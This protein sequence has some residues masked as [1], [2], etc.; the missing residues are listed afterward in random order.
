MAAAEKRVN[1]SWC[2]ITNFGICRLMLRNREIY[3]KKGKGLV[4]LS[5]LLPVLHGLLYMMA[6][7]LIF[8]AVQPKFMFEQNRRRLL[9]IVILS[10]FSVIYLTVEPIDPLVYVLHLT[11]LSI[12]LAALYE[13]TLPGVFTWTAFVVCGIVIVGNDWIST[14]IACTICLIAGLVLHNR[15]SDVSFRQMSIFSLLLSLLYIFS[16]LIIVYIQGNMPSLDQLMLIVAA[17]IL[18]SPLVSFIYLYVKY[19][20]RFQR[21]LL[22]SEKNQI[23]GQLAAALSHEV[24]NPLTSARGF[25]QLLGKEQLSREAL[26]RY[27][28]YAMEGIDQANAIITDYLNFSK[29]HTEEPQ[30]LNVRDEVDGIIPWLQP[31]SVLSNVTLNIHHLEQEPMFI[32]GETKKFQQCLLN[33]MKNAIE[34]MPEGGVLTV[35]TRRDERNGVQILIRDTGVGMSSAQIKRLGNPYFTTKDAGTGLGLMVVIN[36][37]KAMNGKVVFSSK[38]NE[39]TICEMHFQITA[40][41]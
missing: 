28:T 3:H 12:T 32:K 33:V 21:E 35:V 30:L 19:Q 7:C 14:I 4:I 26:D 20:E 16:Y 18:S 2:R 11:P 40:N 39:G 9:F 13:G 41:Q 10:L 34:S 15:L 25:L 8:I 31:Y 23:I 38:V 5:V 24:R 37:V 6:A 22:L 29:P 36:L 27:R 1:S 17:T